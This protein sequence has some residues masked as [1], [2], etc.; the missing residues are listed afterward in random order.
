L[1]QPPELRV[2]VAQNGYDTLQAESVSMFAYA[3]ILLR[4]RYLLLLPF[5]LAFI[6]GA[7]SL[8]SPR[9][10]TATASFIPQ[11]PNT[12]QSSLGAIASQFGLATGKASANSPQFYGDLLM[13]REVLRDVILTQYQDSASGFKGNLIDYFKE[14]TGDPHNDLIRAM[15]HLRLVVGTST[16]PKT[17]LVSFD[18]DTRY[19][20]LSEKVSR[21]FLALVTDYNMNRRQSVARAEREFVDKQLADARSELDQAE[22]ALASFRKRNRHFS[23]DAADLVAEDA[24]LQRLVSVHQQLF[25][26]LNQSY[27]TAR[28]EEVR[29]TPVVSLVERPEGLVEPRSRGT[30]RKVFLAFAIGVVL[31]VGIAVVSEYMTRSRKSQDEDYS[32]FVALVRRTLPIGGRARVSRR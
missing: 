20:G 2:R 17:G 32:E 19:P 12:P 29:N 26:S 1:S 22:N 13:S 4:R 23:P 8:L 11:E 3:N 25:L 6:A 21:R 31:A 7:R 14:D 5:A 16:D 30:G 9:L 27:Q 18:V 10:Y 28:L 24:R 15:E